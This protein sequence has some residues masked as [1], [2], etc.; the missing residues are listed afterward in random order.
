MG[1][2]TDANAE[3]EGPK[4]FQ[5]TKI[6]KQN[7]KHTPNLMHDLQRNRESKVVVRNLVEKEV[8]RRERSIVQCIIL[9][10]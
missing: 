10:T 6:H 8:T 3:G 5:R 9:M 1:R 4:A 7:K 2:A